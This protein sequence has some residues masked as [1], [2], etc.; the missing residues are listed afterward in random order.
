MKSFIH[1][2][3][4]LTLIALL[5]G[6]L[7]DDSEAPPAPPT[8][9]VSYIEVQ[10]Q[11]VSL[12]SELKGRTV[13]SQSSDI[14]PQVGGIIQQRL[15]EEGSQVNAG[16]VLYQIDPASYQAALQQAKANLKSAKAALESARLT[17]KRYA[18]LVTIQG[19]SQQDAD[20]AHTTWLEAEAALASARAALVTANINL[21]YTRITAPISGRIG[22]S[23]VTPGALVDASQSTALASI[24]TLDP[25]YVDMTQSSKDQLLLRKLLQHSGIKTGSTR[26]SLILE[27]GSRY[28]YQGT[29]KVREVAVNED[30]G[31]VTLRAE[32]ANPD[33][34]LLPGMFVRAVVE[35]AV[36]HNAI[37]LPQ[38]GIS[39][40]S[41]G[42]AVALLLN[43]NNQVEKRIVTTERAIGNQW[44]VS[45]GVEPGDKLIVEGTSKI[46]AGNDVI[47]VKAQVND[48]G[49]IKLSRTDTNPDDHT[50]Q[51]ASE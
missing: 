6:C 33:G 21:G 39:H 1:L 30:T 11:T 23:S 9:E 51:L 48:D 14:R 17:D 4:S 38:Q 29:L 42:H 36:N 46:Q 27:D 41:Q 28:E 3:T 43:D 7:S 18:G 16:D 2:F 45:A 25:M 31:S 35:D 12:T 22:L 10:P 32:F 15:F 13:A 24:N 5:S 49:S 8:P 40:D 47:A 34:L 37:L 44:L 50:P 26:V 19:I 20:D